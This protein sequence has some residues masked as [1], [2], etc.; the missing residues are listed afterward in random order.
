MADTTVDVLS[1]RYAILKK[2]NFPFIKGEK[3]RIICTNIFITN[4][5]NVLVTAEIK[6]G[7]GHGSIVN[8]NM[9]KIRQ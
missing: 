9:L 6:N 7:G 3:V 2:D 8:V 1:N 5:G 4:K